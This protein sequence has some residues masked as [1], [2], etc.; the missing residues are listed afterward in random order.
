VYDGGFGQQGRAIGGSSSGGGGGC[1]TV[2]ATSHSFEVGP[3]QII[4]WAQGG[5]GFQPGVTA[6]A[7]RMEEEESARQQQQATAA[8]DSSSSSSGGSSSGSAAQGGAR[9]DARCPPQR[10]C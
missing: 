1:A 8:G 3:E 7:N 5:R 2:E 4:P 10:R 6:L 9:A